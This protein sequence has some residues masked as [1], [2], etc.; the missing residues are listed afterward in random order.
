MKKTTNQT[1]NRGN[2]GTC[3]QKTKQTN[4]TGG[5]KVLVKKTTKQ[6]KNR[7]NQSTCEE[8]Q[9]NKPNKKVFVQH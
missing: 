9:P 1:K 3:E 8:K 7:G 5:I 4:Q 2:Q 6:T